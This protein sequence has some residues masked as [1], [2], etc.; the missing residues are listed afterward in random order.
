MVQWL[1]MSHDHCL[2]SLWISNRPHQ[3]HHVTRPFKFNHFQIINEW[4]HTKKTMESVV[5]SNTSRLYRDS[6]YTP[7]LDFTD[8][9]PCFNQ[10]NSSHSPY[11][12]GEVVENQTHLT[13]SPCDGFRLPPPSL[14][15]VLVQLSKVAKRKEVDDKRRQWP[16][17]E[18]LLSGQVFLGWLDFWWA[19]EDE[20]V[21]CVGM[22]FCLF[23][24]LGGGGGW[25]GAWGLFW[26]GKI[27]IW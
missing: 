10:K 26:S 24:F 25:R 11:F 22:I 18:K 5:L 17:L 3:R 20:G 27:E 9:L 15:K 19:W 1:G 13:I 7:T 23:F 12:W 8:F 6:S 14:G 4:S 21:G 16:S 2:I